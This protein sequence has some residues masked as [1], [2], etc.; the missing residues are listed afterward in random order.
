[1]KAYKVYWKCYG[2]SDIV[3]TPHSNVPKKCGKCG[4]TYFRFEGRKK[5]KVKAKR[6]LSFRKPLK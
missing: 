3:I 1:M 4:N 6:W 5:K 2:C